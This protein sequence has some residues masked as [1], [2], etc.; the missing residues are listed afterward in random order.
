[1]TDWIR[2]IYDWNQKRGL[3]DNYS[4]ANEWK[5]LDEEVIEFRDAK[6]DDEEVDALC[7]IIVVAVGAI[8]KKGYKVNDCMHE[9]LREIS[10]R[11]G[12]VDETGKW[13]KDESEKAQT[14]WYKA[15]YSKCKM[16]S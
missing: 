14:N 3:L 7:D 5:M 16:D 6:S 4:R 10:S 11:V 2:G 8:M 13:R 15:D 1:M 12:S 9:T